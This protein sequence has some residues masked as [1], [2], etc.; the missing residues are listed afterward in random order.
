[1]IDFKVKQLREDVDALAL[2]ALG[3]VLVALPPDVF[4]QVVERVQHPLVASVLAAGP[5]G[6]LGVRL[7]GVVQ[8]GKVAA[9]TGG[10]GEAVVIAAGV[11]LTDA[12]LDELDAA[13]GEHAEGVARS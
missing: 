3:A 10:L 4:G 5:L 6:R 13:A 11:P 8:A 9:A 2:L 7:V 1:M 12:D